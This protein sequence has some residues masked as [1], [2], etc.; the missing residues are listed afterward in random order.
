MNERGRNTNGFIKILL[1]NE[2]REGCYN[3]C[4]KDYQ[5]QTRKAKGQGLCNQIIVRSPSLFVEN[6]E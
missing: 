6:D 3:V 5:V 1:V 4:T 2:K